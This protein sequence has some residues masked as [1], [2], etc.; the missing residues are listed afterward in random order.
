MAVNVVKT[1][2]G[3]ARL[4][5]VPRKQDAASLHNDLNKMT[6]Y[7]EEDL[8]SI[9]I[10]NRASILLRYFGAFMQSELA[11]LLGIK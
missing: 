9:N 2:Q 7:F 6:L 10:R 4:H 5:G 1:M 11:S 8:S 3:I